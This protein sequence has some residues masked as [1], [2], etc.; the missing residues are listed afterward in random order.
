MSMTLAQVRTAA[1]QRADQENSNFVSDSEL[2][3]YIQLSYAELYDIITSRFEDYHIQQLEFT[4]TDGEKNYPLPD[5]FYKL[6]GVDLSADGADN[7]ITVTKWNF[8]ERN[9]SNRPVNRPLLGFNSVQY[10]ILGD[11]I[12]FLPVTQ[13]PG[14]YRMWYIPQCPT[15]SSDTSVVQGVNGWEEY[16]IVDAAIKM[17]V[18]EESDTTVLQ[19]AKNQMLQRI[20]MLASNRDAGLPERTSDVT[21][22]GYDWPFYNRGGF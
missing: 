14:S 20:E 16:V 7:W 18:K 17:L 11:N 13:A 5:D 21:R 22:N 6:R 4:I 3:S 12:E 8:Q 10:R 2:N 9:N 1:R 19:L 15:L